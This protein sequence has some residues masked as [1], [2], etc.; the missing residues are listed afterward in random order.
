[1]QAIGLLKLVFFPDLSH[2]KK[3][4]TNEQNKNRNPTQN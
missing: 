1:M 3:K 2:I 4:E